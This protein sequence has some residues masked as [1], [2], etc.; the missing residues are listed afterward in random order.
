MREAVNGIK[1]E[2]AADMDTFT[3]YMAEVKAGTVAAVPFLQCELGGVVIV[4]NLAKAICFDREGLFLRQKGIP[5]EW[6][7]ASSSPTNGKMD[8]ERIRIGPERYQAARSVGAVEDGGVGGLSPQD[9]YAIETTS[10]SDYDK[11]FH[12][13]AG[14]LRARMNTTLSKRACCG[15]NNESLW[16]FDSILKLPAVADESMR[17]DDGCSMDGLTM[18]V[19]HQEHTHLPTGRRLSKARKMSAFFGRKVGH[20]PAALPELSGPPKEKTRR[21]LS[22]S[23]FVYRLG[24]SLLELYVKRESPPKP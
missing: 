1:I 15:T 4:I 5:S 13:E 2:A 23:V 3:I 8:V 9:F 24:E 22:S 14:T 18:Q 17:I 11:T 19:Y 7:L 12:R 10:C 20:F 6:A 16:A 21:R